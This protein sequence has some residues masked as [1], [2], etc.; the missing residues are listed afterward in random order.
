M[1][2][3]PHTAADDRAMLD[4]VGV[5]SMSDLF[6]SVPAELRLD[7][8]L[9]VPAALSEVELIDHI[10]ELAAKCSGARD[11]VCFAGGGAY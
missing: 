5:D 2:F 10:A 1:D 8:D 7:R 4:A 3:V 9:E 6:E 11:L